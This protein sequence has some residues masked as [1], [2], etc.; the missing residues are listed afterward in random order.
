MGLLCGKNF[1]AKNGFPFMN[2]RK[3]T[4]YS[5]TYLFQLRNR[6]MDK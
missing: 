2:R 4:H 5:G 6:F 3:A 1:K